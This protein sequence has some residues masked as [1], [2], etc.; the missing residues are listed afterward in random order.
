VTGKACTEFAREAEVYFSFLFEGQE[1][2]LVE[3]LEGAR[4]CLLV[5]ETSRIRIG[6]YNTIDEVNVLVGDHGARPSWGELVNGVQEWYF[7]L[8]I[9]GFLE[10][11]VDLRIADRVRG[12]GPDDRTHG[13]QAKVLAELL[14]R[15][16]AEIEALFA[17]GQ[18]PRDIPAYRA[19]LK[20]VEERLTMRQAGTNA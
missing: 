12:K 18:P 15:H 13:A 17:S 11:D 10:S 1:C 19:Y 14:E 6:V 20:K 9:V 16:F 2:R 8:P 5:L 3:T 4:S 7:L